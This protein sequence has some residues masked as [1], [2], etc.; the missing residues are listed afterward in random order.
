MVPTHAETW[1]VALLAYVGDKKNSGLMTEL[2]HNT[3]CVCT[4]HE[5]CMKDSYPWHAEEWRQRIEDNYC[6]PW[7][8]DQQLLPMTYR[9]I[10][11]AHETQ[12]NSSYQWL[13]DQWLL[14]M[15]HRR[16][17]PTNDIQINDYCP[18][19]TDERLL[20]MT[21]RSM[22]TVHETQT[23]SSYQWHTDQWL[24]SMKHR[25]TAATHQI[26]INDCWF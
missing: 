12:T 1:C 2:L 5:A 11:T 4:V 21:Y 18:W 17:A 10:I 19:N 24:L 3:I 6:C 14:P 13:T 7:N 8:T 22:I 15:K 26:Q 9:S 20:P 16:T 23:N 25:W